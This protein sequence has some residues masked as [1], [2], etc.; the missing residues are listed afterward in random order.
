MRLPNLSLRVDLPSADWCGRAEGGRQGPGGERVRR[1]RPGSGLAADS[2]QP[3]EGAATAAAQVP[4]GASSEA[5]S[6]CCSRCPGLGQQVHQPR[7]VVDH[8]LD[9]VGRQDRKWRKWKWIAAA[10]VTC[11]LSSGSSPP[12][13]SGAAKGSLDVQKQVRVTVHMLRSPKPSV[14]HQTKG[15]DT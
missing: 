3:A 5:W 7:C 11:H 6:C 9:S 8:L 15:S 12:E 1:L 4:G 14:T 2:L 10:D 13:G